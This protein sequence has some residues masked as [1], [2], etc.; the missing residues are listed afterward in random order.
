MTTMN[1][2]ELS[3]KAKN[4]SR[5]GDVGVTDN[6]SRFAVPKQAEQ[7]LGL[8]ARRNA[9][10]ENPQSIR[11]FNFVRDD[12]YDRIPGNTVEELSEIRDAMYE[13]LTDEDHYE[14]LAGPAGS[15]SW[16]EYRQITLTLLSAWVSKNHPETTSIRLVESDTAENVFSSIYLVDKDGT[17]A[18]FEDDLEYELVTDG[19]NPSEIG[20]LLAAFDCDDIAGIAPYAV[21]VENTRAEGWVA[22]IDLAKAPRTLR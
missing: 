21:E 14:T 10:D 4:Q 15:E 12:A 8:L 13:V 6:T 9:T 1:A 16:L 22:V 17:T 2:S 3:D 20:E 11:R 19:E 18:D 5:N 7:P